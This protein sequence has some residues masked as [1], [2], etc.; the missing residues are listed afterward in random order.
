MEPTDSRYRIG[1]WGT[2]PVMSRSGQAQ[3]GAAGSLLLVAV[4]IALIVVIALATMTRDEQVSAPDSD[5]GR[6]PAR[7]DGVATAAEESINQYWERE[8]PA[9]YHREFTRLR[10]GF[11]PETA[12]SPPFSCNGQR[13]TYDDLRGN[14]FYCGGPNDDYIAWDAA[15]LFPRLADEFGGIAPAVVLAHE[16]GHAIQRRARVEAPSV[17]IEL[18][19]DC[20]AG[21]W[22]RFAE[23]STDDPVNLTEGALDSAVGTILTLRD[24]PGTAATNPQAHGLGFDRVNAF[25]TGYEAGAGRCATFP[26]RGVVTTE[27]PFRT[28]IEARTGGNL[29]F[30]KAVGFLTDQLDRFWISELPNVAAGNVFQRPLRRPQDAGPLPDCAKPGG[31]SGYCPDLNAAI[32]VVPDLAQVHER[33]GDLATGTELSEAWG[34]AAQSQ[35]DLPVD[36]RAASLQRD[37]F[38]G[39]WVA[40][41]AAAGQEQSLL[42]PGDVDEVLATIVADSYSPIAESTDSGGAFERTRALRKGIFEGSCPAG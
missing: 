27:L 26:D 15:G 22:V 25:Q 8:F 32:W 9:V 33:I 19:A 42:S 21:S 2:R 1:A 39:A 30:T 34:V 4:V 29:P 6:S 23:T 38:T 17:V 16:M 5:L 40:E 35:A 37:C 12:L 11:Q 41:L 28:V 14:A 7:A 36:G 31:I 18:Q 20:F 13:L 10:G 3:R 24:Q